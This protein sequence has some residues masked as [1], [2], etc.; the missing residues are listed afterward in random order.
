MYALLIQA[1]RSG[2]IK[3]RDIK[4]QSEAL[5]SPLLEIDEFHSAKLLFLSEI[6]IAMLAL[7]N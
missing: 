1:I 7:I 4:A 3:S 6:N 2:R 5:R